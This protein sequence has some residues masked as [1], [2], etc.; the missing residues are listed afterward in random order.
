MILARII[1]KNISRSGYEGILIEDAK[2]IGKGNDIQ[3]IFWGIIFISFLN[4]H[5]L[6]CVVYILTT[7]KYEVW[8][9]VIFLE[10]CVKNSIHGGGGGWY[11]SMHCRWY[12]SMPCSYPGG[13]IPACLAGLQAHTQGGS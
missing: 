10:A 7:R 1:R 4:I 2:S 12:P 13:C 5:T 9:K 8:G 3:L 11:P 6:L